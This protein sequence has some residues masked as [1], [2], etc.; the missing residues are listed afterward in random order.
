MHPTPWWLVLAVAS[1]GPVVVVRGARLGRATLVA[2]APAVAV[3]VAAA[4]SF[5]TAWGDRPSAPGD[6]LTNSGALIFIVFPLLAAGVIGFTLAA[7][8]RLLTRVSRRGRPRGAR[9]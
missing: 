7:I 6:D 8:V 3:M 4:V 9:P 2:F 1:L 5:P